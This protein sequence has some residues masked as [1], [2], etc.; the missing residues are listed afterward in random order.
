ML[1]LSPTLTPLPSLP[2]G[3]SWLPPSSL[4]PLSTHTPSALNYQSLSGH[5]SFQNC[6]SAPSYDEEAESEHEC[7]SVSKGQHGQ[8]ASVCARVVSMEPSVENYEV[9]RES[10]QSLSRRM[11][12]VSVDIS[13]ATADMMLRKLKI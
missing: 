6:N 12:C 3:N 5:R 8:I 7:S 10:I 13:C 9:A 2:T 11:P 4:Y 1:S